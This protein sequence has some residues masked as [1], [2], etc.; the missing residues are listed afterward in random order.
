MEHPSTQAAD[1]TAFRPAKV[2]SGGQTGVDR[3]GLEA[4]IQLGI[5]HGGWCPR[6]RLAEDGQVPAKYQLDE[7]ESPDYV[8]RTE[9][10]V[11]DADATLILYERKLSGGTQ[12]T[13]SFAKRHDKPHVAIRIDRPGHVAKARQ[14]LSAVRP[15][16]L[17]VAGPRE[18]NFPGIQS[19]AEAALLTILRLT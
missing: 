14:W 5:P 4:A 12:L 6:G 9:Q 11:I 16:I 8:V 19:R 10:N 7:L 2:I 1:P 13:K 15:Q 18:S 17:N 3:A